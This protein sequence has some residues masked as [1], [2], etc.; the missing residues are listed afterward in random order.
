MRCSHI[1][2]R[3][4]DIHASVRAFE[5]A[6]FTVVYGRRPD[7]SSNALIWFE[8]GPFIE[9][10]RVPRLSLPMLWMAQLYAGRAVRRRVERWVERERL[11]IDLAVETD[12][13]TI[14]AERDRLIR[15]G[16]PMS[17]ILNMRRVTPEGRTLRWQLAAPQDPSLPF[18]MSAY[19]P[20]ARPGSVAHAN[21]ATGVASVHVGVPAAKRAAWLTVLDGGDPWIR[22]A[23]GDGIRSVELSGLATPLD[24]A[25]IGGLPLRP[26]ST[27]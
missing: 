16:V 21:G 20:S 9:L 18:A 8:T 11:W 23:D 22:L 24:P 6:G 7:R 4:D 27:G 1:L 19:R 10:V 3:V 17:R 25:F 5:Q 13:E 2:H 26:A 12:D 15:A 14:G